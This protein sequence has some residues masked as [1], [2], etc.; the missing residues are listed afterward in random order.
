MRELRRQALD[1]SSA[2]LIDFDGEAGYCLTCQAVPLSGL[3]LSV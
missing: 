2:H 3:T 1:G